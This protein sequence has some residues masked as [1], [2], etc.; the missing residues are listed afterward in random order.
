MATTRWKGNRYVPIIL[1]DWDSTKQT[2][3]ESLSVVLY[4]GNSYTSKQFVPKGIDITN[5][6]FWVITGNYNAQVEIY[7][8]DV[9][10]ISKNVN[11]NTDDIKNLGGYGRTIE[12]V[13]Q[14]ADD[15]KSL[16]SQL[17]ETTK[18]VNS[19]CVNVLYPPANLE[20]MIADANY[21]DGNG[22]YFSDIEMT[23][24]ATDNS[25]I[26]QNI[27][28]WVCNHG[29]PIIKIPSGNYFLKNYI[30]TPQAF[31]QPIIIG[32]NSQTTRLKYNNSQTSGIIIFKGGSGKIIQSCIQN[33]GFDGL[34]NTYAIEF[35]GCCGMTAKNCDFGK[36]LCG[37][38]F[39]NKDDNEFT[40]LCV[41]DN[42]NFQAMCHRAIEYKKSGSQNSFHG[43]GLINN[44]TIN[45]LTG[46]TEPKILIGSSCLPY[47]APLYAHLWLNTEPI[48]KNN[49]SNIS[50]FYGTLTFEIS[51]TNVLNIVPIN[52]ATVYF[53]GFITSNNNNINHGNLIHCYKTIMYPN[54]TIDAERFK[55][56]STKQLTSGDNNI[57]YCKPQ[58]TL[59]V[60]I[61]VYGNNYDYSWTTLIHK[62]INSAS[63]EGSITILSK[64]RSFNQA[65][66]GDFTLS[67]KDNILILTNTNYPISG[68]T[69]TSFVTELSKE[70]GHY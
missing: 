40:E 51:S 4:Q 48:I 42:C 9:I 68:I 7:H 66:Y 18:H 69:C 63:S 32:D 64:N 50:N 38:L 25:N 22:N 19:N 13:K 37:I 6:N 43:S 10:N 60:D 52:S 54:G 49:G 44:C 29:Y 45:Q 15:I 31:K 1:G 30:I 11:Q 46:E 5:T 24:P 27:I 47:N 53:S 34:D 70:S 58:Q 33:L 2:E 36:N 55:Y 14:N 17:N 20:A 56:Q 12:T 26:L 16:N 62:P 57:L 41:G 21:T 39:H 3:Y 8:N 67:F 35:Q 65:E 23:V 61:A 28:N 59:L